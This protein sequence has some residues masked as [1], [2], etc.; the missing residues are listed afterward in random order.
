LKRGVS[1]STTLIGFFHSRDSVEV[2]PSQN[3]GIPRSF[4]GAAVEGPSSEG[5]F[6]YP[7]YR[8]AG[9]GSGYADGADRPRLL[10]HGAA[11][12]WNLEY[13]PA[14]ADGKGRITVTLDGQKTSV[15]LGAGHRATGARFDRFGI[16]TT[17]IDGNGQRVYFDDLT[18][19]CKQ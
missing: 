5:F 3:S 12:E 19:T 9:D 15:D 14:E 4:L 6:L 13:L 16:V 17:W 10:P 1:D 8:V 11:H 18:Y 2:N 7:M